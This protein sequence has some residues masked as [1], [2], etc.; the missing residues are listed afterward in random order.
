MIKLN[1]A[2]R[3]TAIPALIESQD[4]GL[5]NATH[6]SKLLI[7]LKSDINLKKAK[8]GGFTLS[9]LQNDSDTTLFLD[10]GKFITYYVVLERKH[11][12]GIGEAVVQIALW[13]S[14]ENPPPDGITGKVFSSLIKKYKIVVSDSH[15]T[16]AGRSFWISRLGSAFNSGNRI[17]LLN[18]E[19]LIYIDDRRQLKDLTDNESFLHAWGHGQVY[20]KFRFVIFDEKKVS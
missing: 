15:Q 12:P 17:G 9:M 10:D 16:I 20:S 5:S 6:N 11:V 19:S 7:G 13:R 3:L 8:F 1:A 2:F 4:F 18:G 14:Q